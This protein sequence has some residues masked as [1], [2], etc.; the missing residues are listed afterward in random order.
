MTGGTEPAMTLAEAHVQGFALVQEHT[1]RFAEFVSGLSAHQ[2]AQRVPDIDWTVGQ[3]VTHVHSVYERYTTNLRRA[4]TPSE[5]AVQNDEDIERLGVDVP[6]SVAAIQEHLAFLALI[7]PSVEP[8]QMFPFHAGM[9]TTLA[10]GWGNLLGELLAHGDDIAR[11]TGEGF[12]IPSRDLEVLWRFT[13]P[14]LAGWLRDTA[15]HDRWALRFPFGTVGVSF[16]GQSMR[17]GGE[18]PA[19]PD[20]EI[21][22]ADA[23]EFALVFPYRRREATD[24]QTGLLLERFHRI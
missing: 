17:W 19:D 10:G 7:V 22:V 3:T 16:E 20:H 2:L 15:A 5:V 12:T 6:A 18:L 13:A 21:V 11:A 14:L 4:A 9:Q 1:H 24:A 8:E 23:A